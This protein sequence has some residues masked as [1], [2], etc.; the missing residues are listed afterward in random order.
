MRDGLK[1]GIKL[2]TSNVSYRINSTGKNHVAEKVFLDEL[3]KQIAD[4]SDGE[5]KSEEEEDSTEHKLQ[6]FSLQLDALSLARAFFKS[7]GNSSEMV[8]RA[9]KS[10][11]Y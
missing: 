8:S 9:L 1:H 2:T 6:I 5:L 7:H 10:E 11:S 4:L 3:A